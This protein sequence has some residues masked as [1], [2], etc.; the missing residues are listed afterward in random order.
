MSELLFQT[1]AILV[2][3][4]LAP[5]LGGLVAGADRALTARLQGRIGP[6]LLQP[7]YDAGK[8]WTKQPIATNPWQTICAILCLFSAFVAVG[9]F[10]A[11]SDLLA[12]FF[13]LAACSAFVVIGALSVN[14]PYGQIGAQRELLQM[15]AYEPL[16][17]LVVVGVF[18][19][20]GSFNIDALLASNRPLLLDAPLLFLAFGFVLTIKFRKSPFDIASS[21]HAHQEIVR[22][23]YTDYSGPQLALLEIAHWCENAVLLGFCALF[24]ATNLW[25]G[26]LLAILAYLAEIWVDNVSARLTWRWMLGSVWAAGLA[27]AVVNLLWLQAR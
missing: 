11:Q 16:F 8:L 7:F 22:G 20:T 14:S 24:W 10:A 1:L 12:I 19:K 2:G 5:L 23:V 17:L 4:C 27:L 18:L 25:L 13:A 9:L 6:P 26:A 21:H 15:L 3:L